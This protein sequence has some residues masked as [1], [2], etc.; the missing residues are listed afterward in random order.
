MP[1]THLTVLG[2]GTMGHGIAHAA[3]IAG[4]DTTLYDPVPDAL[5]RARSAIEQIL[6]KSV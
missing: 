6:A 2:A 4:Y 5:V 3:M 1:G